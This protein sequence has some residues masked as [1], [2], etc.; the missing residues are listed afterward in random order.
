MSWKKVGY[1]GASGAAGAAAGY[2]ASQYF[3]M[4]AAAMVGPGGGFGG[5]AGVVSVIVGG[6]AGVATYA[7]VDA[8]LDEVEETVGG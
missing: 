4:R 8:I 6:L 7:V 1:V 5:S 3:G 2:G